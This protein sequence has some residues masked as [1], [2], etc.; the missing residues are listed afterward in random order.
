MATIKGTHD[1]PNESSR[2]TTEYTNKSGYVFSPRNDGLWDVSLA[3]WHFRPISKDELP[4]NLKE[5]DHTLSQITAIENDPYYQQQ[6]ISVLG[7]GSMQHYTAVLN[8]KP[9]TVIK[10][11]SETYIKRIDGDWDKYDDRLGRKILQPKNSIDVSS[12]ISHLTP[13]FIYQPIRQ[14]ELVDLFRNLLATK[15]T[16]LIR[17]QAPRMID[18]M[19]VGTVLSD[20]MG[21]DFTKQKNGQWKVCPEYDEIWFGSSDDIVFQMTES[22]RLDDPDYCLEHVICHELDEALPEK[23]SKT[24]STLPE[25]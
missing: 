22:Q 11:G 17:K 24:K 16:D 2:P 5:R 4:A 12:N 6:D 18:H 14:K 1:D 8:M 15:D 19:A 10:A 3:G 13:L 21:L 25:R 23:K 9:D 7:Y 20:S